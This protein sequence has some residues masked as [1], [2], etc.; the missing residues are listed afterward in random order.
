M[1]NIKRITALYIFLLLLI[2]AFAN[3]GDYIHIL[4][5]LIKGLPYGDKWGHFVLMGLLAFFV[6]ILLNCQKFKLFQLSFLKGSVIILIIVTLEELSQLFIEN[7][8][9]DWLD[10]TFDYLGI[11]VFGQLAWYLTQRKGKKKGDRSKG[12]EKG[13]R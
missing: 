7:R 12:K 11:F 6:N 3:Q 4:K 13:E 1:K 8:T 2:I 9:F 10:L 5:N